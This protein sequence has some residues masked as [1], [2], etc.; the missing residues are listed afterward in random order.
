MCRMARFVF[1]KD[2]VAFGKAPHLVHPSR[3]LP[4]QHWRCAIEWGNVGNRKEPCFRAVASLVKVYRQR[5]RNRERGRHST[6]QIAALAQLQ[7][8]KRCD[9]RLRES[10]SEPENVYM[11]VSIWMR[12]RSRW[13]SSCGCLNSNVM[14]NN[15]ERMY[16]FMVFL[17]YS[18]AGGM[19][20]R[21][22]MCAVCFSGCI[23]VK[24]VF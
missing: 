13:L 9:R 20:V 7:Q 15:T 18:S 4:Y 23:F 21:L 24:Y 8:Q 16:M 6:R 5:T 19:F 12:A 2:K 11:M 17:C 22:G 14:R 1:F 10:V 3:S